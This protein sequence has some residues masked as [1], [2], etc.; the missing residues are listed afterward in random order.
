[1][2]EEQLE[3]YR[4]LLE[5]AIEFFKDQ[6]KQEKNEKSKSALLGMISGYEHA[7]SMLNN[8]INNKE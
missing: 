6:Y 4:S 3:T 2:T 7:L 8:V 1:M 5:D